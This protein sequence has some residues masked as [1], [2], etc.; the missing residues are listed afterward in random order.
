MNGINAV[1]E[2]LLSL[3]EADK[4]LK[5]PCRLQ[6]TIKTVTDH[7][8]RWRQRNLTERQRRALGMI[9]EGRGQG[10]VAKGAGINNSAVTDLRRMIEQN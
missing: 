4:I 5:A 3:D 10:E 2:Y 6:D 8:D 9:L 7:R 1:N